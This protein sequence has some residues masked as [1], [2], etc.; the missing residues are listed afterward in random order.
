MSYEYDYTGAVQTETLPAGKYRIEC[1]GAQGG[2]HQATTY[3]QIYWAGGH[4]GY[5]VGTLTLSE[6]TTLYIYVG[7]EGEDAAKGTGGF[8]GGGNG[9][10]NTTAACG[11]GGATDVRI[12]T[13]SLYHRVIVAGGG[14]GA[15]DHNTD[16]TS[17][18]GGHGGG[19]SGTNGTR[20]DNQS[21]AVVSGN[22]SGT[23]GSQIAAGYCQYQSSNATYRGGFGIGGGRTNTITNPTKGGGGSGWYGGGCGVDSGGGGG[24]GWVYTLS[25][26]SVWN[27]GNPTDAADWG[28]TTNYCLTDAQTL[29]GDQSFPAVSGGTET[30]HEGNG[31]VRITPADTTPPTVIS[32]SLTPNPVITGEPYVVNVSVT[33][34]DDQQT[35]VT[36]YT[37]TYNANSGSCSKSSE[38]V[39]Q[40]SSVTLPT[41]TRSGYTFSGWYTASS[42]GTRVGG[43]G[44]SYTP[45]GSVTLWAQWTAVSSWTVTYNANGGTCST[46]SESVAQGDSVTLPTATKA[47]TTQYTYTLKGWYTAS[48]GGTKAGNAGSS[49]TPTKNITLYAQWTQAARTYSV[50]LYKYDGGGTW[51]LSASLTKG[52][53]SSVSCGSY[54]G[55]LCDTTYYTCGWYTSKTTS[56]R[57]AELNGTITVAGD[58]TLYECYKGKTTGIR[59]FS[60]SPGDSADGSVTAPVSKRLKYQWIVTWMSSSGTSGTKKFDWF[61]LITGNAH[62]TEENHTLTGSQGT[63]FSG[64]VVTTT[65]NIQLLSCDFGYSAAS[66][67]SITVTA[68][69]DS[70]T[71]P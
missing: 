28:L 20:N 45:A 48:S 16:Y 13:D 12:G 65:N 71:D 43:A 11:G 8:N 40:G 7:G 34:P 2:S 15:V 62:A 61:E 33:D 53:G 1:W 14:G 35:P 26:Y 60:L 64:S 6:Q 56:T 27:A 29:A 55:N 30:G 5:S 47:S 18:Y 68:A 10:G 39:L 63:L 66:T 54:A 51:S 21:G 41:A 42:G 69:L 57:T 9:Y 59:T 23:A 19:S 17:G 70:I 31:Y 46:A 44:D 24:S 37:V 52:Y 25:T 3:N 4:G 58:T 32:I 22:Y 38:E 36:Q 49:Y 50:K 67:V